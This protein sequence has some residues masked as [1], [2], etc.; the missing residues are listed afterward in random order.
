MERLA[1]DYI[2]GYYFSEPLAKEEFCQFI[3]AAN[4]K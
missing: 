4:K 1:I 3:L 2:Q